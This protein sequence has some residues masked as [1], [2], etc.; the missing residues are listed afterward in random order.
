VILEAEPP[1]GVEGA[2]APV[3]GV[4]VEVTVGAVHDRVEG[5][6]VHPVP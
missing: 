3:V 1:V 6:H 2:E 4:G 5:L